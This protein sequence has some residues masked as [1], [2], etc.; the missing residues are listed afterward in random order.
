VLTRAFDKTVHEAWLSENDWFQVQ[1][2]RDVYTYPDKRY[3][4]AVALMRQLGES[5]VE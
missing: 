4:T 3:R 1:T 5:N 2:N